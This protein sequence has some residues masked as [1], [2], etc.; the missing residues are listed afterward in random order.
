VQRGICPITALYLLQLLPFAITWRYRS[1]DQWTR[2]RY[3]WWSIKTIRVSCTVT[4]I[5]NLNISGSW[6][7]PFG[8]TLCHVT[9][10]LA[11]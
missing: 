10:G 9:S 1:R 7:W 11:I 2:S 6:P 4:E 8:V 3:R 5:R